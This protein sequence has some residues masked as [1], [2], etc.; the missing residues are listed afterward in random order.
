MRIGLSVRV[1]ALQSLLEVELQREA[2][3]TSDND[4]FLSA[5]EDFEKS[6]ETEEATAT[7]ESHTQSHRQENCKSPSS[8]LDLQPSYTEVILSHT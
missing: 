7:D 2:I 5:L 8:V 4:V 1:P 6:Q 3:E